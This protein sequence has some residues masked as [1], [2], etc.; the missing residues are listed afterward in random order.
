MRRLASLVV[1]GAIV[2][3]M[4]AAHARPPV[5]ADVT[6]T[7]QVR[8]LHDNFDVETR[9][10]RHV[11]TIDRLNVR[12]RHRPLTAGFRLDAV[13]FPV[14]RDSCDSRVGT[15]CLFADSVR[16]EKAWLRARGTWGS[17]TAGDFYTSFGRGLVLSIRKVDE[18]GVDTSIRGGRLVARLGPVDVEALAGQ[19]NSQNI[20]PTRDR[21]LEDPADTLAGA[22]V[23]VHLPGGVALGLRGV[24]T[25]FH[26]ALVDGERE[27]QAL[28]GASL[29]VPHLGEHLGVYVEG[30]WMRR[31]RARTAHGPASLDRTGFAVYG[32]AQVF[33]GGTT[34]T[35]EAKHYRRFFFGTT[36]PRLL[37]VGIVYHEPPTLERFDQVVPSNQDTTGARLLVEQRLAGGATR[38]RTNAYFAWF[39]K[40]L[41]DPL[42]AD[43]SHL[44]HV[45]GEVRQRLAAVIADAGG[46]WREERHN[47]SGGLLRKLWHVELQVDAPLSA[48]HALYL[49]ARH[50]SEVKAGFP[51]NVAFVAGLVTLTWG[52]GRRLRL[53]AMYGYTTEKPG[54]IPVHHPAGQVDW[55]VAH[56]QTLRLFG[57]RTPGGVVCAGGTCV[58]IPAWSGARLEWIARF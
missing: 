12:L 55:E 37:P 41:A 27:R 29:D 51:H 21:V 50:R 39:S 44:L 54:E 10:D 57:G 45:W 23:T 9:D 58:N 4:R 13:W 15:S 8:W 34:V 5:E 20:E 25:W 6:N 43:G 49:N 35:F 36:N 17:V 42:G 53:S 30:A 24:H 16:V 32:E 11:V 31:R 18:I 1:A 26:R 56:G 33:A 22:Q 19:T 46:G 14:Q 2:S 38:L 7:A 3:G 48:M 52:L 40:N 28:A 47:E